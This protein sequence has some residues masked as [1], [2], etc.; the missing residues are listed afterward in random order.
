MYYVHLR[1]LDITDKESSLKI[2]YRKIVTVHG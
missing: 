1:N 2:K